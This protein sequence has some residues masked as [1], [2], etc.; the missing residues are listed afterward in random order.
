[1]AGCIDPNLDVHNGE[2][3]EGLVG[4]PCSNDEHCELE[5]ACV[6]EV[7]GGM[8]TRTC[9]EY[10]PCPEGNNCIRVD[11]FTVCVPSCRNDDHCR[12]EEGYYCHL[13]DNSSARICWY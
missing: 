9:D 8:C 2:A 1:M 10:T 4:D 13:M 7:P 12:A 5:L 11:G 3:G 6:E